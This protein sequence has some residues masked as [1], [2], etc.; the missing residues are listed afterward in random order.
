MTATHGVMIRDRFGN[1][2]YFAVLSS[3]ALRGSAQTL[4]A[5]FVLCIGIV[6]RTQAQSMDRAPAAVEWQVLITPFNVDT[7]N[8]WEYSRRGGVLSP[9]HTAF[10]RVWNRPL[11][12]LTIRPA[13]DHETRQLGTS[14]MGVP[15]V[16]H[17]FGS[18]GPKTL[19]FAA[20]HG[21]EPT[22]AQVTRRLVEYLSTHPEGYLGRRVLVLPVANPDGLARQ[23]RANA[24]QIDLNR[25]FP[26]KNFAV[27]K[28]GRYFG[29]EQPAS[30]P[31]T[32]S[33]MLLIDDWQPD[34]IITIHSIVRGKHGNNFDGPGEALAQ[35]MSRHNEYAVLPSI[36][37]PTPG[38]FGSWA[39]VDRQTPTIT[40]ELPS[41]GT[42]EACWRECC[43]ALLAVIQASSEPER[44][45]HR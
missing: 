41:D 33:L 11:R 45:D 6:D 28:K 16:G 5:A 39:G 30:E 40:L 8:L 21:D 26:S 15:I 12:S 38:S 44:P 7:A 42:G 32:Q 14:V 17:F 43:D 22:T 37:Y 18:S 13:H 23:T 4:L 31:E 20:I 10:G 35:L 24:R 9:G 25:N 3:G 19:I 29:G 27:G 34:R 36:G 2:T 1:M